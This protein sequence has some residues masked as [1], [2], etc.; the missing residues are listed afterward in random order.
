MLRVSFLRPG[1]WS[2]SLPPQRQLF[3]F[4]FYGAFGVGQDFVGY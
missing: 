1:A 4:F 3:F 2:S